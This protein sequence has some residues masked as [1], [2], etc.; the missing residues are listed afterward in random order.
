MLDT[1]LEVACSRTK[2]AAA[3]ARQVE[4]LQQLPNEFLYKLATGEEKL[5]YIDGMGCGEEWLEKFKGTPLLQ[6][7]I[8]LAKQD[9]QLA[10]EGKEQ[11]DEQDSMW[12]EQNMA[13]QQQRDE[14]QIHRKMLE[15][16]LAGGSVEEPAPEEMQAAEVPEEMPPEP[17]AEKP[18]VPPAAK[19]APKEEPKGPPGFDMGKA[20]MVMRMKLAMAQ[21][22]KEAFNPLPELGAAAKGI[23][24]FAMGA[25]KN[26]ASAAQSGGMS[27]A[28]GMAKSVG[29]DGLQM[30]GQYAKA[31]PLMAAGM[32]GA[33]GL[34]AG[35][36]GSHMMG[37][38]KTA[39]AADKAKGLK[40]VGQLLSGSRTRGLMERASDHHS[41]AGVNRIY[42][43]HAGGAAKATKNP[44]VKK[45]LIDEA[46]KVNKKVVPQHKAGHK[47][48]ILAHKE[49]EAVTLARGGAAATAGGAVA[50]ALHKRNKSKTE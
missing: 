9:L 14:L 49:R 1:F 38:Q 3:K 22:N 15:I 12:R 47:T 44:F 46:A 39:G 7:A 4:L 37:G 17:M 8:E 11:Q 43:E 33:A 42:A 20:A 24:G 28:L 29:R 50:T 27:G 41:T 10:I 5:A 23:K 19:E 6:K 35:V 34:G 40:R 48:E 16:E 18:A 31:K 32:A 25:G 21:M 13:R 2:V 36:V 30:A 26:I 45:H